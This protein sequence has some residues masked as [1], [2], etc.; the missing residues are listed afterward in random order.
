MAQHR[1]PRARDH[2][3]R[4][5][6]SLRAVHRYLASGRAA[7]HAQLTA[8]D[9]RQLAHDPNEGAAARRGQCHRHHH[10]P[11]L[12]PPR[13]HV[14]IGVFGLATGH[15]TISFQ[16]SATQRAARGCYLGARPLEHNLHGLT[17]LGGGS[18]R[19]RPHFVFS[20]AYRSIHGR[21]HGLRPR[22]SMPFSI[23]T[24]AA[25]STRLQRPS[26]RRPTCSR[27]ADETWTSRQ[28]TTRRPC[29]PRQGHAIDTHGDWRSQSHMLGS[30]RQRLLVALPPTRERFDQQ[31]TM[32]RHHDRHRRRAPASQVHRRPTRARTRLL[33][34]MA[35]NRPPRCAMRAILHRHPDL[36]RSILGRIQGELR[37]QRH[38]MHPRTRRRSTGIHGL[39]LLT[40]G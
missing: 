16:I 37:L 19:Q 15:L 29:S 1:V 40:Q 8:R 30:H 6:I 3:L 17:A 39:A 5:T 38:P 25:R 13:Q 22:P 33:G 9:L 21:V 20:N 2:G 27:R 18:A 14:R 11:R 34:H 31:T 35:T 4:H 23:D 32:Q 10:V 26:E 7:D 24:E 28:R 12:P 36:G